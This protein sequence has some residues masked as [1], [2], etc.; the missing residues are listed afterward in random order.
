MLLITVFVEL[1]VVAGRSRTRVGSPHSTAV[2]CRGLEKTGMGRAGHGHGMNQTRPRCVNQMRKTHSKP[3]ATRHGRGTAGAR[4]DMCE[5]ACNLH[6]L[7]TLPPVVV[8]HPRYPLIPE[9]VWTLW[10]RERAFVL[11]LSEI[12]S[13]VFGCPARSQFAI[14]TTVP[15]LPFIVEN[16]EYY[17]HLKGMF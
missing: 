15:G 6:A 17:F 4:H 13:R 2:L 7:A 1:R 3:L 11:Y 5:S 8:P 14:L 16:A 12:E 10:K 9:L